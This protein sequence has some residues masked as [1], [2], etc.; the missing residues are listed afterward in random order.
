VDRKSTKDLSFEARHENLNVFSDWIIQILNSERALD[1]LSTTIQNILET[2]QDELRRL[3][4]KTSSRVASSKHAQR[5][6]FHVTHHSQ[7]VL[8][9]Q[10]AARTA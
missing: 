1:L 3:L 5:K 7:N 8:F 4:G 6:E 9:S 10:Y 2:R